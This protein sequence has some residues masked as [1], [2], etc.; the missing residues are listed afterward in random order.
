MPLAGSDA[1]RGRIGGLEVEIRGD[2]C[3]LLGT[4]TLAG[5]IIAL[6]SAVRN[7]VGAGVPIPAPWPQPRAT[8]CPFS[9]FDRGRIEVGQ[10]ADLV[11]MNAD[12]RV[13]RVMRAG[14]WYAAA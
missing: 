8:R 3:V 11:E 7:L 6:D 12:L 9:V 13:S 5:S 2:R 1:T 14:D 10:R 4:N